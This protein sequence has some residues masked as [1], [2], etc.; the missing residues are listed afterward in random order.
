[1]DT[2]DVMI[3]RL[4]LIFSASLLKFASLEEILI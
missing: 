4:R 2:D 3:D 1:M